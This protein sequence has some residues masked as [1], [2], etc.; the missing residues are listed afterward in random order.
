MSKAPY[1]LPEADCERMTRPEMDAM[2]FGS[3]CL[4][5][6]MFFEHDLQ[7]RL[8][9]VPGGKHRIKLVIGQFRSLYKDIC[10]TMQ[11]KQKLN[12]VNVA[13]DMEVRLVPKMSPNRTTV[14][15]EKDIA[16]ELID[17]AQMKCRECICDY[18]ESRNCKL[19][20]L[21]ET[22]I[23]LDRYSAMS[24]PYSIATWEEE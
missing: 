3:A 20:H 19:C 13:K 18:N 1:Q 6:L 4:S 9:C 11:M 2:K 7:D 5:N 22:V 17:A 10:G 23:P 8:E 14:T 16:M 12:L 15:L 21:L 24:C